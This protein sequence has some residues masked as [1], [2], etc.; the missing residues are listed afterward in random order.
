MPS[1]KYS[2]SVVAEGNG[3]NVSFGALEASD[4]V[5]VF[6]HM[7]VW[8]RLE[9]DVDTRSSAAVKDA[10]T[11]TWTLT[12]RETSVVL[13]GFGI[14]LNE[15]D[16]L[17]EVVLEKDAYEPVRA[18]EST[19][20]RVALESCTLDDTLSVLVAERPLESDSVT[21]APTVVERD[22]VRCS[23]TVS[24]SFNV[25]ENPVGCNDTDVPVLV[26]VRRFV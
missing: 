1:R 12:E 10:V 3:K 9:C 4:E 20:L 6:R 14:L 25:C 11:V 16:R 18:V 22:A 17:S 2:A 5:A 23:L 19:S 15:L 21:R 8:V 26:T 24:V 7:I 13:V